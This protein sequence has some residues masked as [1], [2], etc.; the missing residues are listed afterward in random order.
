[1]RWHCDLDRRACMVL[2]NQVYWIGIVV[3]NEIP[4]PNDPPAMYERKS[5][6]CREQLAIHEKCCHWVRYPSRN[7][8][9]FSVCT[10]FRESS[11]NDV[12]LEDEWTWW[13]LV[14]VCQKR[15]PMV[16]RWFH[17]AE[18]P[19]IHQ[20][21]SDDIISDHQSTLHMFGQRPTFPT[22]ENSRLLLVKHTIC[23]FYTSG[24]V[25]QWA[26]TG[27]ELLICLA[28]AIAPTKPTLPI[29]RNSTFDSACNLFPNQPS[30]H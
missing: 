6:P 12:A 25:R 30:S 18:A 17:T 26:T 7:Q 1:M 11:V 10:V 28:D 22:T 9:V 15:H 21:R 5:I 23:R 16:S 4:V 13:A 19:M 20:S 24:E 29:C 2:W 3:T 14:E 27:A 8:S